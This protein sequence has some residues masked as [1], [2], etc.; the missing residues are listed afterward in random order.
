VAGL[1]APVI[2][3]LFAAA[4]EPIT[5]IEPPAVTAA[6]PA[7]RFSPAECVRIGLSRQPAL[8]AHRASVAAAQLQSKALEDLKLTGLIS[9][10]IPIRRRQAALGVAIASA[11]NTQAEWETIYDITRT[12]F[13]VLYATEQQKVA[14]DVV[15]SLK[16]TEQA[17][18]LALKAGNKNVDRRDVDRVTT[19]RLLAE[20]RQIEAA[21]GIER[22]K[23]A[24]REAMGVPPDCRVE[25]ATEGLPAPKLEL[26]REQL[27]DLAVKR[28]GELVQAVNLAAVTELEVEAQAT[29]CLPY[30]R[31]F[32]SVVDI[33]ARPIPQGAR[34]S[35]YRP[36][37]VGPEVPAYLAGHR[38]DRIDRA[39]AFSARAAAVA[40]KTRNLIIL[41]A[42][43]SFF[44]WQEASA[45]MEK[46]KV[47]AEKAAK[48]GKDLQEEFASEQKVKVRDV[49]DALV[50][51]GQARANHNEALFRQLLALAALQRVTAGGFF[52]GLDGQAKE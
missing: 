41:E 48:L 6:A 24:L 14:A 26:A 9:R 33:H 42:E 11:G 31:T 7:A 43:N 12:Y 30:F 32:A 40:D 34:N 4:Q 15:A 10:E 46:T 27:I 52:L 18:D 51:S 16:A 36:D 23:A 2:F 1:G 20:T 19:Y 8:A 47:A 37:A 45:K 38:Q 35:E 17:A 28:R 39:R 49:L 5:V 50:L 22:A 13:T 29:S 25:I 44:Q 21:Q 3:P